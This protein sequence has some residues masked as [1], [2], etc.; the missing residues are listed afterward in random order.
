MAAVI[1]SVSM[2]HMKFLGNTLPEIAAQK[3]GIIKP[4]CVVVTALQ[5][6]EAALVIQKK[7]EELN[8]PLRTADV[9]K[10]SHVRY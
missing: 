8:C 4:G 2:D 3:A 9:R 10:A 5:S 7:A 1:T 6:P